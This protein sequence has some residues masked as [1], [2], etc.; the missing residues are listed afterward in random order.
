MFV[1]FPGIGFTIFTL[2]LRITF[3]VNLKEYYS[4]SDQFYYLP[5]TP[6]DI[7]KNNFNKKRLILFLMENFQLKTY[8]IKNKLFNNG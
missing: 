8:L 4:F 3:T 5:F 1:I 7:L 2:N 6:K